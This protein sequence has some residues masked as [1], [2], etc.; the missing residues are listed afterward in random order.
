MTVG[1][2]FSC[3]SRIL[4]VSD[5]VIVWNAVKDTVVNDARDLFSLLFHL[6]FEALHSLQVMFHIDGIVLLRCHEF[7]DELQEC[8]LRFGVVSVSKNLPHLG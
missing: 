8:S 6:S 3:G 2:S 1:V 4:R 7:S 5:L